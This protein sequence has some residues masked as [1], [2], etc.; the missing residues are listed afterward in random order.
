MYSEIMLTQPPPRVYYDKATQTAIGFMKY[1]S[2]DGLI[3]KGTWFTFNNKNSIEALT[4]FIGE[5]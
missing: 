2:N 3:N 5:L 4:N 1:T